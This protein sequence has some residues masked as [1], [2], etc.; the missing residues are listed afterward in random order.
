M[1]VAGGTMVV[2]S[3]DAFRASSARSNT[4]CERWLYTKRQ[5]ILSPPVHARGDPR[6]RWVIPLPERLMVE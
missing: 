4:T 2:L 1:L 5:S 6:Q 3:R